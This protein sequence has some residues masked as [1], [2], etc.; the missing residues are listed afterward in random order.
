MLDLFL[1]M[2]STE[3]NVKG[4]MAKYKYNVSLGVGLTNT[5]LCPYIV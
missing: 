5:E 3:L 4:V 2:R 1:S